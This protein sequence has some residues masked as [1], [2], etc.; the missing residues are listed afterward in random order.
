METKKILWPTDLSNNAEKALPYV[1]S[2]GEKYQT[3]VHV[4]YVIEELARHEP[5]YGD[6][7]PSHIEKI[8][9][10]E[11]EKAHE[12][13]EKICADYLEG[14]PLYIKHIGIGDPAEEILKMIEKENVDMVVMASKGRKGAFS[15]GSV[16]EKIVKNAP[17]TVI[18][19]P[20]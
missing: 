14:C 10:W 17:V 4:L 11:R 7:N 16:S 13:L 20:A 2:L 6:F 3:E 12:R 5:W 15:F 18:T 9:E 1:Q 8:H 19:V